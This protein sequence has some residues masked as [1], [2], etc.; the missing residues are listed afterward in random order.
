MNKKELWMSIKFTLFSISAGVIQLLSFTIIYEWLHCLTWWPS[1]LISVIL[2]V[3][4]NFTF[5]RKFTFKSANNVPKAMTLV[6]AYYL[7]FIPISVFGG[8]ALESL[9]GSNYG[10]LVTILMMII[11]FI[12]EF[13]WDRF[14]VFR[15]SID[16]N[17]YAKK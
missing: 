3:I 9:W 6:L 13:I 16:T 7:V 14:V 11:N 12:T 10:I 5:N 4:W 17:N 1:Y 15:N 8:N 2:S